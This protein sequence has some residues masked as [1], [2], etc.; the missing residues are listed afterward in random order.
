MTMSRLPN[1]GQAVIIDLG[2]GKDI[3][4]TNKQ[5][6]GRRLALNALAIAYGKVLPDVAH[7]VQMRVTD[8]L[9]KMCGV[10]VSAVDVP[11]EE[12]DR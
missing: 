2:E 8:A 1:T 9:T 7:Y 4:P 5:E 6:V 10:E 12:L 3:H 11:V